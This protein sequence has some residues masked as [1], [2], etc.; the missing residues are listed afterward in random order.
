MGDQ[1]EKPD[2]FKPGAS[3]ISASALNAMRAAIPRM[4]KGGAGIRVEP[5]GDRYIIKLA[6]DPGTPPGSTCIATI[7]A[8][9]D[10]YVM[11][12]RDDAA[13]SVAKPWALRK[14]VDLPSAAT[15]TYTDAMTRTA[16]Q[17][18]FTNETQKLTPAY[19][20]GEEL[21]VVRL[22]SARIVDTN[23]NEILDAN[24][25]SIVWYD[26]NTCGRCWATV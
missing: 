24:G 3:T 20:V 21:L 6:A 10:Q 16:V 9:Y 12:D 17:G 1:K 5:Y 11:C 22:P 13:I 4:L 25:N 15:Y 18:G 19:E 2:A 7:T 8:L 14:G 23:G 26:L